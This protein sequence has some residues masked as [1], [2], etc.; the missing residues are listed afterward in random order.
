MARLQK[1]FRLLVAVLGGLT[2]AASF[3]KIG[4]AGLAWVAPGIILASALG[5]RERTAFRLGY[6]AGFAQAL[7]SLSWLLYIP[8]FKLAPIIG[9]MLLSA[10]LALYT[11]TWVWLCWRIYPRRS[12]WTEEEWPTAG[13]RLL[14]ANWAQRLG[15]SLACAAIWVA[16]EMVQARFLTGFPWNLLGSS[17]FRMLP[18]LQIASFS[19]IYG[20]SFLCVWFGASCLMAAIVVLRRS[21]TPRRWLWE[22][23]PCL[24]MSAGVIAWGYQT[25][26]ATP[27]ATNR[28]VKIALIQP[29]IPQRFIWDPQEDANRFHEL[30]ELSTAAMAQKP[31]L[32]IWPEAAVPGF[33][34]WETNT[35]DAVTRFVQ[36]NHV[37]LILGADDAR[38]AAGL[39]D[40]INVYNASFLVSPRG[41]FV[42]HY[43]KQNLVMFGEYIPFVR[44]FPF[45]ERWTGMGSFTPGTGPALF[46]IPELGLKTSVVI[47]FEDIFPHVVR[48]YVRNAGSDLDFLLNL[49]N[50]GWFGESSAQWQHAAGA[51]FRAAENGLPLVRCANN[52]LSCWVD[53]A[54]RMQEVYFP[55]TQDIY[56]RGIKSVEI[57]VGAGRATFYRRYGDLF[58]WCCVGMAVLLGAWSF[59]R[60]KESAR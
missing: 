58:G 56:G 27:V 49:T 2:M 57:P 37:W 14:E 48:G 16:L 41:E 50:N 11:G 9:W 47:C 5:A 15:W 10:F 36:T 30:M 1:H 8:V 28:T 17:Q 45:L 53:A 7:M 44:W 54:G 38:P 39:T 26:L 24:L 42:N 13:E 22:V 52:G 25:L 12:Q 20:L 34:R 51:V 21:N 4:V 23:I 35:H 6:V 19:G 33:V 60:R 40:K 43:A 31:D 59:R 29:S 32:M 3:P 18:I 55:G 46:E